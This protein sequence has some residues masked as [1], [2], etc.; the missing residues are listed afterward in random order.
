MPPSGKVPIQQR[1]MTVS[2]INYVS[3]LPRVGYRE[4]TQ[5]RQIR[6]AKYILNVIHTDRNR[7]RLWLQVYRPPFLK[8]SCHAY[9]L[10]SPWK[11]HHQMSDL[12]APVALS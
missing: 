11:M 6:S 3:P 10:G 1:K 2:C 7:E 8:G 12:I 4:H 9:L 5:Q